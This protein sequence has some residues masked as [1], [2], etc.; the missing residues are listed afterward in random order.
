MSDWINLNIPVYSYDKKLSEEILKANNLVKPKN[1]Y[2]SFFSKK[3]KL[4][5]SEIKKIY[6]NWNLTEEKQKI[7]KE[8]NEY[9][10]SYY[11]RVNSYK[12]NKRNLLKEAKFITSKYNAPGHLVILHSPKLNKFFYFLIGNRSNGFT[13]GLKAKDMIAIRV[14]KVVND[15]ELSGFLCFE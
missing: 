3:Y 14:K 6:Y 10:G 2:V 9:I 7:K 5:K 11:K 8:I 4:D 15:E 13:S 12:E 1:D